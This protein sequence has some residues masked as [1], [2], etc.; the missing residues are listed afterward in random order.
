MA[1]TT[2]TGYTFILEILSAVG[3]AQLGSVVILRAGS[4]LLAL[5][6]IDDAVSLSADIDL[7]D[8][9]SQITAGA[10][11]TEYLVSKDENGSILIF[12]KQ[13]K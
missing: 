4:R 9:I 10:Q 3:F 7:D 12:S 8:G 5:T 11:A 1:L 13:A 6:V 2:G